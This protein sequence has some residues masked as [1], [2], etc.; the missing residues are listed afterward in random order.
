M[1]FVWR[2]ELLNSDKPRTVID[3]LESLDDVELTDTGVE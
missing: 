3:E 2:P 1:G